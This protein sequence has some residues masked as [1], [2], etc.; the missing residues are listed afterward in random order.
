MTSRVGGGRLLARSGPNSEPSHTIRSAENPMSSV[1]SEK[2]DDL[3]RAVAL[4]SPGFSAL[5]P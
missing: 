1:S 5:R 3:L 2:G 4:L